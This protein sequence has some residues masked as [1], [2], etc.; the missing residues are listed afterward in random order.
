M[1]HSTMTVNLTPLIQAIKLAD[2]LLSRDASF[3]PGLAQLEPSPVYLSVLQPSFGIAHDICNGL[4]R[5]WNET[6]ALGPTQYF[7]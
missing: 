1:Y 7:L 5:I 6:Y 3:G 4:S 2:H